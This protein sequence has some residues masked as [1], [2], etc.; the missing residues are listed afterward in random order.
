MLKLC[1][2][3]LN[4]FAGLAG[5]FAQEDKAESAL[6]IAIRVI[7]HPASSQDARVRANQIYG[8]LESQFTS[9]EIE[10]LHQRVRSE[11]LEEFAKFHL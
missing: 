9:D 1:L 4:A 2:V 8:D 7:E 6:E 5:V 11:T 3:A 10:A